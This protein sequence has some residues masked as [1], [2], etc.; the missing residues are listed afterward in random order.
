VIRKK[1]KPLSRTLVEG[2]KKGFAKM[3]NH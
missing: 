3:A 1:K 2:K